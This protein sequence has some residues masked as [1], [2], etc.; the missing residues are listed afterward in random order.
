MVAALP[1]LLAAAA[2][3]VPPQPILGLSLN[4]GG[5]SSSRRTRDERFVI[6]GG[7]G[8]IGTAVA[9]HLLRR[10][11]DG[12]RVVLVGRD[13]CRG[14][15][16]VGEVLD[17]NPV[18]ARNG[19]GDDDEE[20][21]GGGGVV[22]TF[23]KC[24]YRNYVELREV[25][26]GCTCLIHVAGP[27]LDEN[28]TPL[29]AAIDDPT[30]RAYV[31]VSDPLE[32]IE[33][34]LEMY[35]D[36]IASGTSALLAAGAFPGMSNVMA[37]EAASTLIRRRGADGEGG[38][39]RDVRFNYFTAG[40]GG[41]GDVNLYITNLGFG[42]AMS[43]YDGGIVRPFEALSGSILGR[44]K[45]YLDDSEMSDRDE[46]SSSSSSSSCGFGNDEAR[47]RVG[48][49]TV[50]AWPF[51][52][53]AT[54]P[55]ELG[56]LGG[57]SAAMGTAPDVW[58]DVLGL[59]V[60]IVPRAL[61]RSRRF[62]KFIAD[63]S[64]PLVRATDALLRLASPDGVGETHAMRVDATGT[65]GCAVS[66]V[67]AHESF[68]RCVGQSCAEFAL[69]LLEQPC[70]GVRLPE[71]RYRD[72]GPRGKIIERLTSTPGTFAY[73]GPVSVISAPPPSELEKALEKAK[74]AETKR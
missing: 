47:S 37:V 70:P 54:V 6:L 18:V 22:V 28:P 23:R 19:G 72:D 17:E 13:E 49:R 66:I 60:A 30:C 39:V 25:V 43:Q 24:D 10:A 52:E 59:L 65:D 42:E 20:E 12:S 36:A 14:R 53:A 29:R 40:L 11:P 21:E 1:M 44:V 34:S 51:P 61:W 38:A 67:Q 31:D 26:S 33:K 58:N 56:I 4:D 69:D 35:D 63:F 7:T 71:Q 3:L 16:A 68:R 32:Y 55:A 64:R 48:E 2:V 57:S 27:Y 15:D 73:T 8:R 74:M 50:F 46:S 45:F 41:S 9:S 62:S 5:T